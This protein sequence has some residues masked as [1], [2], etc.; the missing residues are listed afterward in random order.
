MDLQTLR[1]QGKFAGV[2]SSFLTALDN[3][4]DCRGL[5]FD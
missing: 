2:K 1:A 3:P 5:A 4:V